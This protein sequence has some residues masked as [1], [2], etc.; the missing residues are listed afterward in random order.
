MEWI[1]RREEATIAEKLLISGFPH[2][3]KGCFYYSSRL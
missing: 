3:R 1:Y 2:S